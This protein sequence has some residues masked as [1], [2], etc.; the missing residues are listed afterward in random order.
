MQKQKE[1]CAMNNVNTTVIAK[2]TDQL[3]ELLCRPRSARE[4]AE[5]LYWEIVSTQRIRRDPPAEPP[6]MDYQI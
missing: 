2:P 3:L 4:Q 5:A 6:P 1:K